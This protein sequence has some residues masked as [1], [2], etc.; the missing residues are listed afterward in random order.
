MLFIH[1]RLK[2]PVNDGQRSRLYPQT[3]Q[4]MADVM[5]KRANVTVV[6]VHSTETMPGL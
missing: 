1:I 4:L 6:Q 3:T 5:G 2:C